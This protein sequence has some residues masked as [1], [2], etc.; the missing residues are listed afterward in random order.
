L[1]VSCDAAAFGDLLDVRFE[2]S[3]GHVQEYFAR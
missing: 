3:R 2:L 1:F